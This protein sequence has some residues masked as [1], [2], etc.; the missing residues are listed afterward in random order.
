MS[1]SLIENLDKASEKKE[2]RKNNVC[3]S[4]EER[5]G[6]SALEGYGYYTREK[7]PPFWAYG[8]VH[9]VR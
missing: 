4:G 7:R 2:K 6:W 8:S 3:R 1:P 5:L 9:K